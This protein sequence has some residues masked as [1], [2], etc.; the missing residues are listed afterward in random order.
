MIQIDNP[1]EKKQKK[2]IEQ[3]NWNFKFKF[4]ISKNKRPFRL[5]GI[6]LTDSGYLTTIFWLD[7]E[8]YE[9]FAFEKIEPYLI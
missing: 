4:Y 3:K 6:E 9:T 1:F 5:S 7:E 2:I 8:K